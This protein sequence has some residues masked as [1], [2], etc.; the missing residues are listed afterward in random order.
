VKRYDSPLIDGRIEMG[1]TARILIPLLT[2]AITGCNNLDFRYISPPRV[3]DDSRSAASYITN[4]DYY[5]GTLTSDQA[6]SIR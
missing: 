5:L 6:G 4:E 3:N 1:K 2:F